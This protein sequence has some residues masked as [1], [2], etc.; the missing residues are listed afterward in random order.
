MMSFIRGL[1]ISVFIAALGVS[2]CAKHPSGAENSAPSPV[3][4]PQEMRKIVVARVNGVGLHMDAL[5][6]QVNRMSAA[7]QRDSSS[8]SR[9]ATRQKAL[10]RLI[11]QELSVQEAKRQGLTLGEGGLDNAMAKLRAKLGHDEGYNNFL[12]KQNISEAELRSR[13][14]R[15]LLIQ[16]VFDREVIRKVSVT[17]D[18]LRK[19]YE[20]DRDG[21]ITPEKI[22]VVDVIFFLKQDDPASLEKANKILAQVS[23]DK[24]K[25]PKNLVADGTFIVRS[26]DIEKGLEP[27]L[28][29]AARK[30]KEG[31]L[32][33]VVRTHDSMHIIKLTRYTP[34]SRMSFEEVKGSLE[35]K[36]KAA[37]Q[38]KRSEEWEGELR[39][40]AK[41]EIVQEK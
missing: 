24:E 38:K 12:A 35:G 39:K 37:A 26:L 36:L 30:L 29:E 10:D 32:S 22:A 34:E 25:N 28:Y 27:E 17:E 4:T 2:G 20:R 13:V 5:V 33:G 19:E 21:F 1:G 3:L 41:I 8:G 11:F 7:N 18:D 6:E 23:A 14:E 9:E 31:E 16:L 40:N 15:S